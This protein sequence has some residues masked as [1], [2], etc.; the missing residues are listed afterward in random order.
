MAQQKKYIEIAKLKK[1]IKTFFKKL[2]ANGQYL[3]NVIDFNTELQKVIDAAPT[4]DAVEWN[5][6]DK[7]GLPLVSDEY[8]VVIAG[9]A[10][11]TVLCFDE[12]DGVFFDESCDEDVT[13]KVT[14]WAEMPGGPNA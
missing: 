4:A 7:I 6:V 2:V 3:V 11:P 12:D 9:A 13:Y 1:S 10:K 5:A 8:L 14:H